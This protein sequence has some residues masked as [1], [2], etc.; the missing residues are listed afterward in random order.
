MGTSDL[1]S[2]T[3][4]QVTTWPSDWHL[5]RRVLVGLSPLPVECGSVSRH[6]VSELR[7]TVAYLASV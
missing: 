7:G 4:A 5:K 6:T 3:E 1:V 2:W